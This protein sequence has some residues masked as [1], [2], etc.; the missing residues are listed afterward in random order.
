MMLENIE[1][2]INGTITEWAQASVQPQL[3]GTNP[4]I[5]MSAGDK[6]RAFM[7]L[8]AHA[9]HFLNTT[10]SSFN[11]PLE[12]PLLISTVRFLKQSHQRLQLRRGIHAPELTFG[13]QSSSKVHALLMSH[14]H[15]LFFFTESLGLFSHRHVRYSQIPRGP[16]AG[17]SG[18][19][20]PLLQVPPHRPRPIFTIHFSY[21]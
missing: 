21:F 3:S 16:T 6:R 11:V 20:Q 15:G 17:Q 2:L 12:A 14:D 13:R 7:P 9:A 8:H 18:K 4:T 19:S 10:S 1:N 5:G